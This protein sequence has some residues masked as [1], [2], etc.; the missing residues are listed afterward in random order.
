MNRLLSNLWGRQF[1]GER[2]RHQDI[3]DIFRGGGEEPAGFGGVR[4][5]YFI[6]CGDRIVY[7]G[8]SGN[9]SHR[10]IESLARFYHQ[11]DDTALP[12]SIGLAPVT[13]D[14]DKD[15]YNLEVGNDPS[16][17]YTKLLNELESTAIRKYAPIFNTSIPSKLKSQGKEP[18][19]THI[20]R[21]FA[22][23][24]KN[25]TAFELENLEKQV[26]EAENNPSP[27]WQQGN[28]RRRKWN[29]ITNK[30]ELIE[31]YKEE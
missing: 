23:Q 18:K 3:D 22:D 6:G 20:A 13:D 27:P 11:I 15:L 16:W 30:L 17:G 1:W 4:G 29:P 19:I 9:I 31:K 10:S 7:I 8:V 25:C 24:D 5:I 28:K 26:R 12:W 21:V 14:D 2:T